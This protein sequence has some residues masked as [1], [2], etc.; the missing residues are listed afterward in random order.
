[1]KHVLTHY[2]EIL[3]DGGRGEGRRIRRNFATECTREGEV[4][5]AQGYLALVGVPRLKQSNDQ[6]VCKVNANGYQLR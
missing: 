4:D 5:V 6:G 2:R 1:M 3:R